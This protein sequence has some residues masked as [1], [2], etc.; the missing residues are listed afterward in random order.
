[1]SEASQ[2]LDLRG[3]LL[4]LVLDLIFDLDDDLGDLLQGLLLLVVQDLV[5]LSHPL[6]LVLHISVTADTFLLFEVAHELIEVLSAALQDLLGPSEDGD[7]SLDLAQHLLHLLVLGILST[8]V[9]SVLL[10]VITLHVLATTGAGILSLFVIHEL[11]ESELFG[12]QLL[13]LVSLRLLLLGH[14]CSL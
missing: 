10:E 8:E 13:L 12:L 5:G 9:G 7:L 6:K 11:L 3:K 1:M 2:F 4:L 14:C